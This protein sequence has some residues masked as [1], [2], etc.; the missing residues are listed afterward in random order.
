MVA[1]HDCCRSCIQRIIYTT[2]LLI[3]FHLTRVYLRNGRAAREHQHTARVLE[4]V[5]EVVGCAHAFCNGASE[6]IRI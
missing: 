2:R 6:S 3:R 5:H 4:A 1:A